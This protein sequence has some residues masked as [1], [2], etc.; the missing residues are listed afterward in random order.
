MDTAEVVLLASEAI[1]ANDLPAVTLAL[2][3]ANLM[4][5]LKTISSILIKI[6]I[7]LKMQHLKATKLI[8]KLILILNIFIIILILKKIVSLKILFF[9]QDLNLSKM[10]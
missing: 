5:T 7:L 3:N 1:H 9:Q 10:K 6:L 8:I 2:G 4:F